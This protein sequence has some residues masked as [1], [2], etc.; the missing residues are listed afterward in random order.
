MSPITPDISTG[1]FYTSSDIVEPSMNQTSTF[2]KF[3]VED[4]DSDITLA[5]RTN[6]VKSAEGIGA[7]M[8]WSTEPVEWSPIGAETGDSVPSTATEFFKGKPILTESLTNESI[9]KTGLDEEFRNDK[10]ADDSRFKKLLPI[11]VVILLIVVLI[12][13]LLSSFILPNP[14]GR[15][16][17]GK[18]QQVVAVQPISA[19]I[20]IQTSSMSIFILQR[21]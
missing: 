7:H 5:R 13:A 18:V 3:P 14:S 6:S 19:S 20:R 10:K 15:S 12:A 9:L 11:L 17:T 2:G 1:Q 21:K 4:E 8:Y 16:D